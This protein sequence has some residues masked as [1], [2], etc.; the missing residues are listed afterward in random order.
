MNCKRWKRALS[1]AAAALAL[2]LTMSLPAA[3]ADPLASGGFAQ[4]LI[5]AAE[6][7]IPQESLPLTLYQRDSSNTFHPVEE[8]DFTTPV[9]RVTEDLEFHLTPQ[10]QQVALT[11]DY[12]TDLDGNGVYELLSGQ[13]SPVG[14]VLTSSGT[15]ASASSGLSTVLTSGRTYTLTAQTLLARGSAAIRD[16]T[17]PGSASYLAGIA[18][19]DLQPESVLYM[20]TVSYH[21]GSDNADYELCYY[22]RL[23]GQLPPP[24]AADY[25]D[26]APDAWYYGAV[27]FA[28]SRGLLSGASRS[29]FQPQAPL[30]R[31][32]LALTLYQLSGKPG[33]GLSHYTDVPDSDWCYPAISWVSEA[34]VMSGNET[35]FE[36]DRAPTRQE[37]ALTL[38]R[39]A[40]ISGLDTRDQS[41][42]SGYADGGQ[43]APWARS[44]VGWAVSTG[45]LAGRSSGSESLLAPSSTVTRAEFAAVLETLSV[46]VL[47]QSK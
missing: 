36:P 17:T 25:L 28:V 11:V 26:V 42:L 20:I 23:Y 38:Y 30:T 4:V 35:A 34:G 24:S 46:R 1:A 13:D 27:D 6:T 2:V 10:T 8:L 19:T 7:D 29:Y 22:L 43:V 18:P 14:D 21:S 40:Q 45:L 5:S 32:M 44:A 41:D 15:L 16:R 9:N 33:S 37:L 47:S 3:A 12:L 39:F 31:A